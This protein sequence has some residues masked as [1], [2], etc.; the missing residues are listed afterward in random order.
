MTDDLAEALALQAVAFL[1]ADD[2]LVAGFLA[3]SGATR[4][5]LRSRLG[6]RGFLVG[7]LDHLLSD[8]GAVLRFAEQ[9]DLAPETPILAREWLSR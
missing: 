2:D 4:D 8:D 1:V 9:V 5:D 3:A 6:D 7:A